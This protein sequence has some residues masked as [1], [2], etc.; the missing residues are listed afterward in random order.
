M[1]FQTNRVSQSQ[2]IGQQPN[3]GPKLGLN[4]TNLGPNFFQSLYHLHQLDTMPVYYNM[5]YQEVSKHIK[6]QIWVI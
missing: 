6:P 1:Q 5:Q 2:D 3:F 4:G